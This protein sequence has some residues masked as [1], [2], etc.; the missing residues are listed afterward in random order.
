MSLFGHKKEKGASCLCPPE[1]TAKPAANGASAIQILGSGCAGCNALEAETKKALARLGMDTA[2]AHV[3]DFSQIAAYGVM[4]T[5]ALVVDGE[6]LSCGRV[7][8]A[9]EIAALLQQ[10]RPDN[11]ARPGASSAEK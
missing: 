4:A 3:T 7:L 2:V 10:K 1:A 9:E 11:G 5:P 6:V 8:K